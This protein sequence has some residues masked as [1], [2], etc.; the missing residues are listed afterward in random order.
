M[1]AGQGTS[2]LG[3]RVGA[4]NQPGAVTSHGGASF[5]KMMSLNEDLFGAPSSS[6]ILEFYMKGREE[7]EGGK[8]GAGPWKGSFSWP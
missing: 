4:P 8:R 3:A 7:T 6:S 5:S 2:R 1:G